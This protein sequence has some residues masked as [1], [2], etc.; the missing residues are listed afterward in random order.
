M[1]RI[2]LLRGAMLASLLGAPLLAAPLPA[3]AFVSVGISVGIAPPP[4]PVYE[5]PIAPGPGYI[6]TP[7][8]W[9]WDGD[10]YYWVPGTWVLPPEVGV[11][12]TPGW[13]GWDAGFYRWH[14]GYWGPRVG[15]YGGYQLRFRLF[16]RRLCRRLLARTR[17]LLQPRGQ[18]H[19]R[20]QHPQCV[21][22][23]D[24]DQQLP[25]RCLHARQL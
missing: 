22:G 19:Q 24:R 8:Y 4:L 9:A 10:G 7:G 2:T 20:H 16:R 6:W 5:Q 23:Q 3:A 21:R 17:F 18:Q 15:F 12:W 1:F 14:P 11:L 25:Q 13:W